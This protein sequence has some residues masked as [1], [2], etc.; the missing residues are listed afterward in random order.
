MLL[1]TINRSLL[2]VLDGVVTTNE[3]PIT[4]HFGQG[5]ATEL[6]PFLQLSV[7]DGT[8]DVVI[9]SI[10]QAKERKIVEF[11]SIHNADTAAATITLKY[12]DSSVQ[13]VIIKVTLA[14]GDTLIYERGNGF[15]T[16]DVDGN[17]Q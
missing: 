8:T 16:L 9:L 10:P 2:V 11:L 6:I 3:L 4:V 15:K 1:D 12:D 14:T 17:I 13:T 5:E 7:T